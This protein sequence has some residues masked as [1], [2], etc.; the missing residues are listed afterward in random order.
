MR[1]LTPVPT[2]W[3][4]GN[5]LHIFSPTLCFGAMDNNLQRTLSPSALYRTGSYQMSA[6]SDCFLPALSWKLALLAVMVVLRLSKEFT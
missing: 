5:H 2:A 3:N 4:G 6:T 1:K